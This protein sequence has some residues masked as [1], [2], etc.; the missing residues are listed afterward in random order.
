M[1]VLKRAGT[2]DCDEAGDAISDYLNATENLSG[3][4]ALHLATIAGKVDVVYLL[5]EAG[6]DPQVKDKV[7]RRQ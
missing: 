7:R 2:A 3:W 6:C 4:T 5:M 1:C